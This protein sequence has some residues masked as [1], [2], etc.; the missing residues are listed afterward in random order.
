MLLRL[1]ES[2]FCSVSRRPFSAAKFCFRF[3]SNSAADFVSGANELNSVSVSA[4][5]D[6]AAL[7][8]LQKISNEFLPNDG[9]IIIAFFS[10]FQIRI[11]TSR[12]ILFVP[13]GCNARSS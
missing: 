9:M 13:R 10:R 7:I 5:S 8:L 1:I 6:S 12:R 3:V 2:C 11:T 4:A